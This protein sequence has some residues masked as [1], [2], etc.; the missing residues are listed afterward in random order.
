MYNYLQECGFS[1]M[2]KEVVYS[3][4]KTKGN[5]D[6]DLLMQAANDLYE[7][8]LNKA[9]VVS[10]DGDYTPLIKTLMAKD[11]L[12]VILS[13]SPAATCSILLKRTSAPIAYINDQRALLEK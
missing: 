1:L 3:K 5:C 9:I 10:S 4:G 2:F 7:G 11:R 12:E 13:P 8:D 6:S